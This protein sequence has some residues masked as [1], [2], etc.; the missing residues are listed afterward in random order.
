MAHSKYAKM[1]NTPLGA[2]KWTGGFWGERFNVYSN[3]SLQS[4]WATWS[5][6][7]ISHGFRNFEIAAGTCEGE[8]WGPPFHDGDMYKWLEAV[9]AVYAV[10]K[11]PELD[12]LMDKFIEQVVKAQRADGYIHTPVIIEERNKGIDT[13]SEHRDQTVIGTKVGAE[14]EKGAFANRLNFETYNLGHLMMAGITHYR[15]TGKRTLFDAAIKA[16]D[17]LCHFYETASAELARNAIC[18]SHYMGV[19]EMY[20]ATGNPRYLELSKNLIDIR[21]MVE[22]GTDDNQ[23]RIPFREQYNA[24][25]HAVRA[26]YLYAGVADVY[27]ETGEAQLMKNLTSIWN[28]IVNRKMY[29]TGACGA[30]YD[31]TSP[32][33]TCYEPDSI[34][35][36]H[37]S[38]GRAYQL[39]NSTAHNETC[40]NIGNMLFNWRM[41]ESTGDAK[42]ADI[43]ET[44]LYN[45]V[46]SGVSLDGKRYFYTNPLRLSDDFP[47][48]L[49]WPRERQE[50]ISCFCCPPNTLRTICEAQ[51]YAYTVSENALWCN[52][53]GQSELTTKLGKHDLE[54]SQVTGYPYDGKVML[55]FR[56]VPK[57]QE[58]ALHLRIPAWCDR[59][60]VKVNGEV[61]DVPVK[62]NT[63]ATL[64]RVW[65]KGDVVELD[66]EMRV[67]LMESNPLVEETRNQVVVKRGPLVYCLEGMDVA[68]G[69]RI[70]DVLIPSTIQFTPTEITIDGSKM[71]ALDGEARLMDEASWDNVLYREV[72]KADRTVK[73]R[74]IPYFAWG[75]RGKSEMTVWMPLA[76]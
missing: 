55:T 68:D 29:V 4:M 65:K 27:A 35:K 70:D 14:D 16:T 58:M 2:V 69:R 74:L 11:D 66:M 43:V 20:R 51:N 50:Y 33:G 44:A 13:H 40:A 39:P 73:I 36:V 76:K 8:H 5:N 61:V 12:A 25:G 64:N 30:L 41:L 6:P 37:Q 31:G 22:N 71:L 60:T 18:P 52:L 19:V 34:Q 63:Y 72:G 28:D 24:M 10:N 46:L 53:Y 42:Y 62:A 47:Y 15:A 9:A 48:T 21:G 56:A 54:V 32:D 23:D 67:K 49:R 3:T 38:Y 7:D 57:K 26:N 59:A 1:V 45:S 17:F 75:N